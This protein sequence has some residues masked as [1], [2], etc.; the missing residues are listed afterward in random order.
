M[1]SRI[2][3]QSSTRANAAKTTIIPHANVSS[4][5]VWKSSSTAPMISSASA[6]SCG[7]SSR[8]CVCSRA[9]PPTATV[10]TSVPMEVQKDLNAR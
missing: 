7:C 10:A 5:I 9:A 1:I 6:K 2:N 4:R 3:A 8:R